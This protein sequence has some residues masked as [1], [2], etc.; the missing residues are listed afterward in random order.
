MKMTV[1]P[2][3]SNKDGRFNTDPLRNAL[4]ALF[5]EGKDN[6]KAPGPGEGRGGELEKT[7]QERDQGEGEEDEAKVRRENESLNEEKL[8]DFYE[9]SSLQR[10]GRRCK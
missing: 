5:K 4:S 9:L 7:N 1:D 3:R 2:F 6:E 10:R 8:F